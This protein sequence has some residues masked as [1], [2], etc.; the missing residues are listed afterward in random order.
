[1]NYIGW[2]VIALVAYTLVAPL[3]KIATESIPSDVATV[4]SNTILVIVALVV[5][6][7]ADHPVAEYVTHPKAPYMYAAGFCLAVG[8][9]AY[10]RALSMGPVSVV[11][12]VFGLFLVTSS[13]AGVAVLDEPFTA[14]KAAGIG[15]A[16]LAVYFTSVE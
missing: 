11:T 13:I 14:R 6:A 2:S 3:M 9:L 10:Y 15:F 7:A 4:V 1:M 8:I 5:V 16:L 12:P